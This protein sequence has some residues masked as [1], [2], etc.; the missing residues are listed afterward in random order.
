MPADCLSS[1]KKIYGGAAVAGTDR[2]ATDAVGWR[3]LDKDRRNVG[4]SA[5]AAG[6]RGC[7]PPLEMVEVC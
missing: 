6:V 3:L 2:G 4:Q 5:M 1:T 7:A